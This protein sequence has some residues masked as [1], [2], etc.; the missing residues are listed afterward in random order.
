[1]ASPIIFKLLSGKLRQMYFFVT[2][3]LHYEAIDVKM[4]S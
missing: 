1:M 2:K 4:L 3:Y